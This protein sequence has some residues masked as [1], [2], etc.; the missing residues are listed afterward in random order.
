MSALDEVLPERGG[1]RLYSG[2]SEVERET[3]AVLESA[4]DVIGRFHERGLQ[5]VR[6]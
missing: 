3:K 6:L 5:I 1:Q 4:P 2:S